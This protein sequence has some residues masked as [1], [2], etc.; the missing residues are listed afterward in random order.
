MAISSAW[1]LSRCIRRGFARPRL[2]LLRGLSL[3]QEDAPL[4]TVT[5]GVRNRMLQ[6]MLPGRPRHPAKSCCTNILDVLLKAETRHLFHVDK[7]HAQTAGKGYQGFRTRV[8]PLRGDA[9]ASAVVAA[10][11][12]DNGRISLQPA[13][14]PPRGLAPSLG[15]AVDVGASVDDL[16]LFASSGGVLWLLYSSEEGLAHIRAV[17]GLGPWRMSL[18]VSPDVVLSAGVTKVTGVAVDLMTPHAL[19]AVLLYEVQS[20]EAA[21]TPLTLTRVARLEDP[22]ST[23]VLGEEQVLNEGPILFPDLVALSDGRVAC[24]FVDARRPSASSTLRLGR[25]GGWPEDEVL[26]EGSTWALLSWGEMVGA[27]TTPARL[28]AFGVDGPLLAV[29]ATSARWLHAWGRLVA[30]GPS[31]AVAGRVGSSTWPVALHRDEVAMLLPVAGDPGAVHQVNLEW[32]CFLPQDTT[33]FVTTSCLAST[34]PVLQKDCRVSCA[35]GYIVEGQGPQAICPLPPEAAF[36]RLSGCHPQPCTAPQGILNAAED[37]C[38]SGWAIPHGG[39][40]KTMCAPGFT[41]TVAALQCQVG[42]FQPATFSCKAACCEEQPEDNTTSCVALPPQGLPCAAPLG[43]GLA[44]DPSC[45]EGFQIPIGQ[46][47]RPACLEGYEPTVAVLRCNASGTGEL[48]PATFRCQRIIANSSGSEEN[49]GPDG[50][51]SAGLFLVHAELRLD[52]FPVS[53]NTP[54]SVLAELPVA[55]AALRAASSADALRGAAAA[56]LRTPEEQVAVVLHG[57]GSNIS[58]RLAESEEVL[59]NLTLYSL[60]LGQSNA[61]EAVLQIQELVAGGSPALLFEALHAKG[62]DG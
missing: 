5:L 41:P 7:F 17:R 19:Y 56:A 18:Q 25:I 57:Q 47:C 39:T 8:A 51:E 2:F 3:K 4:T 38:A 1:Q 60:F 22:S 21:T 28:A 16:Q 30:L 9:L 23:P 34:V 11:R 52:I 12:D 26:E 54:A 24:S 29:S 42:V 45:R 35:D 61:T 59:S 10:F 62:E 6:T 43:V 50:G 31:E 33:G 20:Q 14:L 58:R 55:R 49:N 27:G 15:C 37:A 46:R 40:C 13:L 44:K 53:L 32:P 36:F 48:S